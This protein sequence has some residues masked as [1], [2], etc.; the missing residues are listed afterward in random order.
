[1]QFH[2]TAFLGRRPKA[3]QLGIQF[4]YAGFMAI[5]HHDTALT[6]TSFSSASNS[7]LTGSIRGPFVNAHSRA[8]LSSN[9]LSFSLVHGY[10][11][12]WHIC[13]PSRF[14]LS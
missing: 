14:E 9:H 8:L 13:L 2:E 5:S 11:S 1:M 10:D 3:G 7:S 12:R 4:T 6:K